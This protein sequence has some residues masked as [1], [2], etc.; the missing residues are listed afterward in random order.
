M[1]SITILVIALLLTNCDKKKK[2][3]QP[4]VQ[5]TVQQPTTKV[6][7]IYSNFNG[8]KAYLYCAATEQERND[9]MAQ[10]SQP[11]LTLYPTTE[12]KNSCA[13]CQ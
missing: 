10:Y 2:T 13:E 8:N 7:C 1:K 9:K 3:V 6:W 11:G 12:Q 5:P 4:T